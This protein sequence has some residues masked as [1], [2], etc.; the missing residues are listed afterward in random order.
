MVRMNNYKEFGE[1]LIFIVF[2][3]F[4]MF[5][6]HSDNLG[7]YWGNNGTP[8]MFFRFFL[9]ILIMSFATIINRK[10]VEFITRFVPSSM[11]IITALMIFDYY[12]TEFSGSQ[13]LYRV[14]WIA[15]II[16]TQMTVFITGTF[17]LK[18]GYDELYTKLWRA[19]TPLYLFVF[20]I[21][22]VRHP[23]SSYII[24]TELGKGNF[25]MLLS[26]L[27]DVHISFEAPLMFFGNI[28]IFTPLPFIL[29]AVSKKFT[30]P[31]IMIIGFLTPFIVEGYQLIF[32]CGQVD[33]DD[34][35]LNFG[36]FLISYIIYALIYKH[37][38]SNKDTA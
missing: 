38:F 6:M 33:I 26:F 11:L 10:N 34:I 25:N 31:A 20:V 32:K 4:S 22:F 27:K 18:S 36:G 15:Y 28:V 30:P 2:Y 14:W 12:V 5:S 29:S 19:F 1:K 37:K 17:V 21:C 24:N 35:V 9:I 7:S 8:Y 16:V 3:L 13:F 23:G